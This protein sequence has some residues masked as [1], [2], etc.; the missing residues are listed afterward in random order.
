MCIVSTRDS[1]VE[2]SETPF[3][4]KIQERGVRSQRA[5]YNLLIL[6]LIIDYCTYR[7]L[8]LQD[9]SYIQLGLILIEITR[10]VCILALVS[11]FALWPME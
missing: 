6:I 8:H 4:I 3:D 7:I 2:F 1:S 9:L 11:R 10:T 5:V